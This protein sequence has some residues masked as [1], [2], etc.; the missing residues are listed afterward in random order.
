MTDTIPYTPGLPTEGFNSSTAD[1]TEPAGA[2]LGTGQGVDARRDSTSKEKMADADRGSSERKKTEEGVA[3]FQRLG[4]K[5]LT[6]V[7]IVNAIALGSLSLPAA[8]A[9]LGMVAGVICCVGMGLLAIYTSHIVGSV[10]LK[11]PAVDHYGAAMGLLFGRFGRFGYEL[12]SAMFVVELIL[13][14][15]SHCLTGTIAFSHISESGVC[16][17]AFG[18]V[19]AIILLLLAIP[20][21]FTEQAILGYIDFASILG[22]IGITM[23]ATGIRSHHETTT[24]STWSA[25]PKP[26][27]TFIDG[28]VAITNIVFAYSFAMCQFTFMDELKKPTDYVKSIWALGVIEIIIYT[29]T[30]AIIYAFVGA[31]V[32]S[33]ALLSAGGQVSRVAFGIALPVIFISGSINITVA[34]RYIHGRIFKHSINRFI[35]TPMGWITWLAIITVITILAFITAEAIPIFSDLLSLCSSLFVSGFSFYL[36]ALMWY[37]LIKQGRWYD[38]QNISNALMCALAFVVGLVVLGCG[39]YASIFDIVS[40]IKTRNWIQLLQEYVQTTDHHPQ[41]D[42][43]RNGT[44][45][46][47]FAC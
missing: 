32:Q 26:G 40:A 36:P 34:G 39:T 30:G 10:K 31:D 33:P 21:S 24:E 28:F 1:A 43:F 29:L 6:I 22:A 44:V 4:W 9:T 16:S 46:R 2:I 47:V 23:I 35:N 42:N 5:R 18:V 15:G 8:F 17:V 25:W 7:L 12:G 13:L 45:K 38:R 14:V 20:P 37:K 19:S 27:T 3:F 41:R 11:F